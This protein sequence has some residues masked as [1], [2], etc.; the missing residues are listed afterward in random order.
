[1]KRPK[2]RIPI[3]LILHPLSRPNKVPHI[4][5]IHDPEL[6]SGRQENIAYKTYKRPFFALSDLELVEHAPVRLAEV[7]DVAEDVVNEVVNLVL[8][9]DGRVGV[10]KR[11]YEDAVDGVEVVNVL[12]LLADQLVDDSDGFISGSQMGCIEYSRLPV[13]LAVR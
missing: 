5:R 4:L 13:D 7:E 10:A 11:A 3:Q 2:P 8:G 9:N 6:R 12:L 1:M